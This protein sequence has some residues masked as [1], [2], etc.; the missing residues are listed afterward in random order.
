MKTEIKVKIDTCRECKLGYTREGY[1]AYPD[2]IE[3][4][5]FHAAAPELLE[6]VVTVADE[7]RAWISSNDPRPE[8][9]AERRLNLLR[10]VIAKAEGR[11]K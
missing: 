10:A 2:H 9:W 4:C 3:L 7:L 8:S 5:F 11:V 6:A 1:T